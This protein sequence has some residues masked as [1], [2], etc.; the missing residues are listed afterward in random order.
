MHL[1]VIEGWA[2][3]D[4]EFPIGR[5]I[6]AEER[7]CRPG[8]ALVGLDLPVAADA[9]ARV[10]RLSSEAGVTRELWSAVAIE[11][12]RAL[13]VASDALGLDADRVAPWLDAAAG[14]SATGRQ[15]DELTTYAHRLRSLP[16]RR[17]SSV[18]R[19]G[20]ALSLPSHMLL[21][22]TRAAS[23]RDQPVRT[24]A[25]E[26]LITAERAPLEWEAASAAEGIS[27]GEWTAVQAARAATRRSSAAQTCP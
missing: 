4:D 5:G 20:L 16:R 10:E 27:L 7:V 14:E 13:A 15:R 22:W 25:S 2:P 23:A 24:W 6:P 3:P 26:Q 9:A 17:A 1:R 18:G 12:G 21:S 19:S 11:A 8:V